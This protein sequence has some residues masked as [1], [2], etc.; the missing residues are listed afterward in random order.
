MPVLAIIPNVMQLSAAPSM[1]WQGVVSLWLSGNAS[2]KYASPGESSAASLAWSQA[3]NVG[4][5]SNACRDSEYAM[6]GLRL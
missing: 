1:G 2:Y 6:L 3:R 5:Q 4:T